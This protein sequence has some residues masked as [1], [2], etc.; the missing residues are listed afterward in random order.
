MPDT[1]Q[2]LTADR[3]A[4]LSSEARSALLFAAIGGRRTMAELDALGVGAGAREA[5]AAGSIELRGGAVEFTHPLLASAAIGLATAPDRRAAHAA[6]AGSASDP[7]ERARHLAL[8]AVG[9]DEAVAVALDGA[10][11]ANRARGAI[12]SAAELARLAVEHTVDGSRP[13]RLR[14]LAELLFDA[15]DAG[16]A[17]RWYR[18][19]MDESTS[20]VERADIALR[21]VDLLYETAGRHECVA[22]TRMAIDAAAGDPETEAR[23]L[24]TLRLVDDTQATLDL[25]R[26]A[27]RLLESIPDADP[28]L[29][30]WA[31]FQEVS[32]D[33]Y[34]GAPLDVAAVD[35]A[36]ALERRDRRWRSDDQV[37]NCRAPLLK[38][39]DLPRESLA[40][41]EELLVRAEDEGNVGQL[42]YIVGHVVGIHLRLGEWDA[43]RAA[44]DR[45]LELAEATGQPAQVAQAHYNLAIVAL[46]RGDLDAAMDGTVRLHEFL[47][48]VN[49]PYLRRNEAALL[50]TI[51]LQRGDVAVALAEAERWW[52][53]CEQIGDNPAISRL[54]GEL[55]E[56]LVLSGDLARASALVDSM[57]ARAARA[58]SHSVLATLAR[59]RASVLAAGGDVSGAMVAISEALVEHELAPI[60]LEVGRT[61]LLKGQLHRR[62]KEKSAA[63]DVLTEAVAMFE[64]AGALWWADRARDE[65]GRVNIRPAAP[66]ELTPTERK[67]AE[68]AGQGLTNKEIAAAVF[69]SLKT[70]EANLA[71]V[72]RKL[73]IRSRV[74]LAARGSE[75]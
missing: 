55:I 45:H 33:Y 8:A 74:E 37:A 11:G 26:Q 48:R 3:L 70:V 38:F 12:A 53:L 35:E 36:L 28:R 25:T 65:L 39:G 29:V 49:D 30:A 15:G 54:H 46:H 4:A 47:D 23:A 64:S 68:L 13:A 5:E 44:A 9:P 17:E 67:I 41:F 56:A 71:R 16:E 60:P 51:A 27:R 72:Y 32:D 20:G 75:T 42:P 31:M 43:A 73:G 7:E 58:A 61:L 63:R 66:L 19:A 34:L 40:A 69:V 24:L 62:A 50:A 52:A 10:V 22:L 18:Q 57:R 1:L 14:A 6:L 59:S 2:A 21:L